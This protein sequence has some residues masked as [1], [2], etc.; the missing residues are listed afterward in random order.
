[1]QVQSR[2][3]QVVARQVVLDILD[4]MEKWEDP[5]EMHNFMR[6]IELL[7]DEEQ[8]EVDTQANEP[9]PVEPQPVEPQPVD[10]YFAL[11]YKHLTAIFMYVYLCI[12]NLTCMVG[13]VFGC[14]YASVYGWFASVVH[15]FANIDVALHLQSFATK[16]R[17]MLHGLSTHAQWMALLLWNSLVP[18]V[19]MV[20]PWIVSTVALCHFF[21]SSV[22]FVLATVAWIVVV[23]A[24]CY[25]ATPALF[26]ASITLVAEP[27]SYGL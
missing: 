9:Q 22:A 10:S 7:D 20:H 21:V 5:D 23:G 26:A 2:N 13:N 6:E 1:M 11:A 27:T 19:G 24:I 4:R 17:D 12:M 16:S 15:F 25:Y 14:F 18:I 8:E 3:R